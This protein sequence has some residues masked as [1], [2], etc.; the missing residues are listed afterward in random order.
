MIAFAGLAL[1][2]LPL[3]LS[4][5]VRLP[6]VIGDHMVVQQDKPVAVW[7]WANKAEPVTV[8][9][10]GREKKAVAD[11]AG[12][13]RVVFDPVKAGGAPLEMTVRGAS[14]PDIV[15]RDILVGEVWL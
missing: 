2:G 7:G 6:A 14:G 4:A 15:V 1:I 9:F 11:A 10:N 12:T 8:R 3:A 13:W 5:A